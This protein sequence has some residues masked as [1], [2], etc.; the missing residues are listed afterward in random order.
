M[1][2]AGF[3]PAD[4]DGCKAYENKTDEL[5]EAHAELDNLNEAQHFAELV[6]QQEEPHSHPYA[7]YTLGTVRRRQ[8]HFAE[9]EQYYSQ[10]RHLSEIN[11]D[12]YLL[13]YAWRALGTLYAEQGQA[14]IARQALQEALR[15]STMLGID[16]GMDEINAHL[17]QLETS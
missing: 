10:C 6:L 12:S 9:A 11:D 17:Q 5:A 4:P 2:A 3:T 15:L 14:E 13:A 8:Q 16:D 1:R 7:L